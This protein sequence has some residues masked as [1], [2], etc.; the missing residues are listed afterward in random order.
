M[1]PPFYFQID[2]IAESPEAY[3][4]YD[5][6]G[7]WI[8]ST[9]PGANIDYPAPGTVSG[10]QWLCDGLQIYEVLH[11]PAAAIL[12]KTFSVYYI[13]GGG[14]GF[15]VL[16]GDAR[17]PPDDDVWHPLRFAY[18]TENSYA[19]FLTNAGDQPT[20]HL[21]PQDQRWAD[22]VLPRISAGILNTSRISVNRA[23]CFLHQRVLEATPSIHVR[24]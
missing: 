17:D 16:K 13:S 19:S 6:H 22:L 15:S 3:P 5:C 8:P 21:Q 14:G 24:K 9:A 7:N 23:A 4:F 20:L 11:R 12:Y 18:N 1:T 10:K 2:E